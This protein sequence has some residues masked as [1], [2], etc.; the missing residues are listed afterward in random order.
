MQQKLPN[1]NRRTVS[2]N[3][4]VLS[5]KGSGLSQD[6]PSLSQDLNKQKVVVGKPTTPIEVQ[7]PVRSDPLPNDLTPEDKEHLK[8]LVM[9]NIEV[10]LNKTALLPHQLAI[11]S[12]ASREVVRLRM[13][14][15]NVKSARDIIFSII[16]EEV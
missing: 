15:Q 13:N 16:K 5:Q 6:V 14:K 2:Q 12:T 4:K 10:I 3:T 8:K 9:H 7:T 1:R 11:L